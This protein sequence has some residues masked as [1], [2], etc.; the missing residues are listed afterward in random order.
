MTIIDY[1][2]PRRSE[3]DLEDDSIEELPV[4]RTA[5]QSPMADLDAPDS[6]EGFELPGAEL[7]HD[8]PTMTVVVPM[9]SDEFRCS[10][11]ASFV[12]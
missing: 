3:C 8:E 2:A 11:L 6:V 7:S 5:A 4:G 9:R 10:R 12:P 1:D